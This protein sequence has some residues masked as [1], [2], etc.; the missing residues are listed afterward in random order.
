MENTN[1]TIVSVSIV[2]NDI[3][4]SYD[5]NNKETIPLTRDS[6][7]KMRDVWLKEQPPF[8]SDRY[9][10]QMNNIILASIQNKDKSISELSEFFSEGN[11]ENIIKFINYMRKRDLTEEKSK[12]TK[13]V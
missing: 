2:D 4:L 11:E 5:N 12:W 6:Y 3:V 10:K 7:T 9:K 1:N 13:K 8:I